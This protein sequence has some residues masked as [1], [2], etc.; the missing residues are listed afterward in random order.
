MDCKMKIK[1]SICITT[2]QI[3]RALC[4]SKQ[5]QTV[6]VCFALGDFPRRDV[7]VGVS[8]WKTDAGRRVRRP[9]RPQNN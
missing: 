2:N 1:M 3:S 9:K 6:G 7:F 8:P 4:I 5:A